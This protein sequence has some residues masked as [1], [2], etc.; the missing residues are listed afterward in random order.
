MEIRIPLK[1]A[2]VDAKLK[3]LEINPEIYVFSCMHDLMVYDHNG[4]D[5]VDET[6]FS[7]WINCGEGKERAIMFEVEMDQLE[8]FAS[9]ILKDI[10]LI[11]DNYG[12]QIQNQVDKGLRI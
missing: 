4:E 9:A 10:Q 2:H 5:M 6:I 1:R 3:D 12:K 8:Q 7:L 11:R